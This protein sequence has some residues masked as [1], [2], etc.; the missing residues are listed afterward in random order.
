MPTRRASAPVHAGARVD[1]TWQPRHVEGSIDDITWEGWTEDPARPLA[2]LARAHLR[3]GRDRSLA[4]RTLGSYE[5]VAAAFIRFI[6][7]RPAKGEHA[8]GDAGTATEVKRTAVVGD[9]TTANVYAFLLR[10]AARGGAAL[11]VAAQRSEGGALRCLAHFGIE[12]GAVA[13]TAVRAFALPK[14][15]EDAVP[16]TLSDAEV[17]RL[18]AVL[19]R[20]TSYEG[21]RL[22]LWCRLGLDTGVRPAEL[23]GVRLPEI[24]QAERSIRIHCKGAK[25]RI[26][27][28]GEGTAAVLAT[29]LRFRGEARQPQLF[30]G[31]R[32]AMGAESFSKT[33]R[34]LAD[35]LGLT[36]QGQDD[37]EAKATLYVLRRTFARRFAEHG[38]TVEELARLM[39]H[40]AS[41]IPMLLERYYRPSDQR[42]QAAHRRIRP[43]DALEGS[44][45]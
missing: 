29:Y 32:G 42:L 44:A 30:L 35:A 21:W 3:H 26:V 1:R 27:Y 11:T 39:G 43:L 33:F 4:A 10:P 14:P 7:R 22:H 18:L 38:G 19:A 17:R 37:A 41:S 24:D 15:E 20:D 23:A 45:A 12:I 9:L 5:Q 36:A 6:E 25:R 40:E 13:P 31:H 28:Y 2:E 34:V 16:T 8:E